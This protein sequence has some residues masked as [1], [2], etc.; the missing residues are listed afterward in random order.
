METGREQVKSTAANWRKW[1]IYGGLIAAVYTLLTTYTDLETRSVA[2]YVGKLI[3]STVAGAFLG[4][5]AALVRNRLAGG[6]AVQANP[7]GSA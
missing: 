3:G 7:D 6:S 5:V 4:S 2:L 1:A